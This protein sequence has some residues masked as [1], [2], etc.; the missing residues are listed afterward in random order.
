M[1]IWIFFTG[2]YVW[3]LLYRMHVMERI[4]SKPIPLA[5]SPLVVKMVHPARVAFGDEVEM[6]AVIT[7]QGNDS[8]TGQVIIS[9]ES[10]HALPNETTA[11]KLEAL[12]SH[13]TKTHR[14]KFETEPKA[15][16]LC[17]GIVR[18]SL[19]TYADRRQL[20]VTNAA[21]I[22]IAR[23]PYARSMLLWLRSS[24]LTLAVIIAIAALLWEM[25]RKLIFKWEA[26]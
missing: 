15:C 10:A 4:Y 7:N 8:F 14:L 21:E 5:G 26:K 22:P 6:D 17:G 24:T 2:L 11:I 1:L 3:F 9:L 19:L 20:S 25:A 12:G 13:E 18:T 23:L 16:W